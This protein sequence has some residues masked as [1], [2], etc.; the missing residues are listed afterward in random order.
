MKHVISILFIVFSITFSFGQNGK[1]VHRQKVDLYQNPTLTRRI[2]TQINGQRQLKPAFAYLDQIE[3]ETITYL[4]DGLKVKGYLAYPKSGKH[5][6][7]VIYNRGGNRDF[8]ALNEFK[9]AFILAK[10]AS[11]GYMVAASQYRGN[12]GGEG[13]E[14][15]GG[16]D[17]NDVLNLVPAFTQLPQADTSRIGL[18]GWSR[19]G[20]MT[21][22]ALTRSCRFRAA[23][24]G[25][26]LTDLWAWMR[27]RPDT[28]ESV[29]AA[30]I[31]DYASNTKASLDAR[32]AL[33]QVDHFC[34][35][36]PILMLHGS[37]DWRVAPE[38]ALDLSKAFIREKV[39]HR[40]VLFEGG[41]HGLSE[42][43]AEVDD[44]VK[45]WLAKY[46]QA[47]TKLPNLNPH[48]K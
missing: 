4:S 26:G 23:V 12:Q 45:N 40:L 14:E 20:M 42:F 15:F 18:Y 33:Q 38:M 24:V 13:R 19:G 28:I 35:T 34:K 44:M 3:I 21:Y 36:T 25:A 47:D 39:P 46:L 41:N 27:T 9:A 5:L 31:P 32:S 43:S 17:V 10:V 29:F 1:I 37:A 16:S 7:C 6:P 30:N 22:L 11:W 48:G 2:S 8:A